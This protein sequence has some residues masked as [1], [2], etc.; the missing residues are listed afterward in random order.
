MT[1]T[2]VSDFDESEDFSLGDDEASINDEFDFENNSGEEGDDVVVYSDNDNDDD[3]SE[4]DEDDN[5]ESDSEDDGTGDNCYAQSIATKYL[6]VG[7]D[8]A[9][10]YNLSP[11]IELKGDARVSRP[12]MTFYEMVRVVGTRAQQF[13]QGA[14]PLVDGIDDLATQKMAYTELIAKM[15]PFIIK[16]P[17]P[18]NRFENWKI[19]EL[20]I[21]HVITD[22]YF[23]PGNFDW[24]K[25]MENA[26]N[27]ESRYNISIVREAQE[28]EQ[29]G[30]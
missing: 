29:P 7:K 11:P 21:V 30:Y 16:R 2:D 15:T 9:H 6:S 22:D 10:L 27:P 25:L 12:V 3:D 18:G 8:N 20:N 5:D 4:N 24:D 17:L 14:A 1:D 28:R 26:E 19:S 23:L 13:N